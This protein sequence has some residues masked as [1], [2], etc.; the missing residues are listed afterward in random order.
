MIIFWTPTKITQLKQYW[1]EGLTTRDIG[2]KLMAT[3]NA[4]IGK[5]HR[6]GLLPR[7]NEQARTSVKAKPKPKPEP[8]PK[9]KPEPEPK[10]TKTTPPKPVVNPVIPKGDACTATMALVADSCRW[11]LGDPYTDRFMYCD[12]KK[13]ADYPYCE[14]HCRKAYNESSSP[15][16]RGK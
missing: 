11:P 12:K 13:I 5:V 6:L 1:A 9:L 7:S 3:R 2:A 14:E 4:V 16:Y 8:E 10:S 15:K